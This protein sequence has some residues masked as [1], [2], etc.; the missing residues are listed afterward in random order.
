MSE[1]HKKVIFDNTSPNVSATI[2][3]SERG[4]IEWT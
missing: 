3:V 1:S 4:E 2:I